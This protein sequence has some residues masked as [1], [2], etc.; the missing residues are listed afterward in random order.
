MAD[1][2]KFVEQALADYF[3]DFA[4]GFGVPPARR[5]YLEGYLQAMIDAD[6]LT[7]ANAQKLVA[8]QCRHVLGDD[9]AALYRTRQDKVIL[10]SH[11]PRAPVYPSG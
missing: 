7:L 10:H 5:Y 3:S 9:A 2:S 6:L 11:M 1:V 8:D 4:K